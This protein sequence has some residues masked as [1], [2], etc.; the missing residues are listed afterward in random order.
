M[1]KIFAALPEKKNF[2]PAGKRGDRFQWTDA[3]SDRLLIISPDPSPWNKEMPILIRLEQGKTRGK[4][5]YPKKLHL[6]CLPEDQDQE[7]QKA[8][9]IRDR[10]KGSFAHSCE[11]TLLFFAFPVEKQHNS[12]HNWLMI[13]VLAV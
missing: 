3:A 6:L 12:D 4:I 13:S 1:I 5:S 7:Y 8:K 10:W 2:V 11:P 9:I